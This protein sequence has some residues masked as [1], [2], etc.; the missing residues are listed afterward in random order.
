MRVARELGTKLSI[1]VSDPQSGRYRGME[2][3]LFNHRPLDVQ[4][5]THTALY[6]TTYGYVLAVQ[7][8]V[9]WVCTIN[10]GRCIVAAIPVL[11]CIVY[12]YNCIHTQQVCIVIIWEGL[13]GRLYLSIHSKCRTINNIGICSEGRNMVEDMGEWGGWGYGNLQRVFPIPKFMGYL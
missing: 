11:R 6:G 3:Q 10:I 9:V 13:E 2:L 12:E 4:Q 5:H 7:Y 1:T 8:V